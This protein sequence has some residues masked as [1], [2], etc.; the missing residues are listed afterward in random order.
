MKTSNYSKEA[1]ALLA[2]IKSAETL[3]NKNF[4]RFSGD[5]MTVILAVLDEF[6]LGECREL[7]AQLE[8]DSGL[9]FESNSKGLLNTLAGHTNERPMD[10]S[11][12]LGL[13]IMALDRIPLSEAQLELAGVVLRNIRREAQR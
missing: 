10:I 7:C 9:W 12:K 3:C 2:G 8:G 1:R 6:S 13:A 11:K 5:E 4:D